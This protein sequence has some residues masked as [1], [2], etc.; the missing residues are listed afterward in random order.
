MFNPVLKL[1][2]LDAI[3][4]FTDSFLQFTDCQYAQKQALSSRSSSQAMT[5]EF[6]SFF[7]NSEIKQVS[8]KNFTG[9]PC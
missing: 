6:G 2:F 1:L 7:T 5:L 4:Q 3:S 8:N 9:V